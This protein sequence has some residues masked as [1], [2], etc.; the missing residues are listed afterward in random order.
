VEDVDVGGGDFLFPIVLHYRP[1]IY[2]TILNNITQ[3]LHLESVQQN[4][5]KKIEKKKI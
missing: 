5:K 2:Y 1:T 3:H 4:N